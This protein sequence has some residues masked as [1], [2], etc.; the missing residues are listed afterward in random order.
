MKESLF[1]KYAAV[2]M[3]LV[4]VFLLVHG[5]LEALFNYADTRAPR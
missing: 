4:G 3:L 5:L 2:L 1:R